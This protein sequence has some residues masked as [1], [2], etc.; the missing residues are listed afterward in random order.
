MYQEKDIALRDGS[1]ITVAYELDTLIEEREVF[2][3]WWH[4]TVAYNEDGSMM[5][6]DELSNYSEGLSELDRDVIRSKLLE[7]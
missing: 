6:K 2:V 5:N 4:V 3:S 1:D 7:L